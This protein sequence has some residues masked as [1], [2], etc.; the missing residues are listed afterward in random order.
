[1]FSRSAQYVFLALAEL[2]SQ[3]QGTRMH[4]EDMA[5]A[6]GV[7]S[8]FLSKLM[9]PLVRAGLIRST[10]G[11]MGGVELARSP[12]EI[13]MADLIRA[14]DGER[15]FHQCP[16]NLR[17]CLGNA[18]CPLYPIWDPLRDKLNAMLETTTLD[19]LAHRTRGTQRTQQPTNGRR[20][21]HE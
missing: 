13:S 19:E 3:P 20:R 11:R 5:A 17:P 21:N 8:S 9:P 6:T 7:P 16:F 15:F 14:V 1:M 12:Q 2:A 4:T 10:R 18:S